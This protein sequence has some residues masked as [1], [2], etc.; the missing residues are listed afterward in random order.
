MLA[1]WALRSAMSSLPFGA[2]AADGS[3]LAFGSSPTLAAATRPAWRLG[4][5]AEHGHRLLEHGEVLARLLLVH[6]EG[7]GRREGARELLAEPLLLLG[8]RLEAGLQV[9]RHHA[10]DAVAV[11]ADQ[12]AQEGDRQQGLPAGAV[13]LLDDDLGQ[14]GVGEVVAGLGVEHHEITAGFDHRRQIIQRDVGAG[15]SIVQPPVGV[16]LDD[17]RLFF[18]GGRVDFVGGRVHLIEHERR[19]AAALDCDQR[20]ACGLRLTPDVCC[21]CDCGRDRGPC[22]RTA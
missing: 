10:L 6:L 11:E 13:F 20:V 8:Q 2:P 7:S 19:S 14:H 17:H 3:A 16:L 22:Y 21:V 5:G 15:L 18:I 9:A 4:E 1:S 12:L